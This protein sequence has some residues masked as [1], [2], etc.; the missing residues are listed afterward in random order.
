MEYT[1][2]LTFVLISAAQVATPGPSTLLLVN[3]ALSLGRWRA[4][5]AL[6]GDLLAIALLAWLSVVGIAALLVTHPAVFMTVRLMGAAYVVWLGWLYLRRPSPIQVGSTRSEPDG[7]RNGVKL[8]LYSFG[9]GISNPKAILF[10]AALFPQ[11]IPPGSGPSLLLVLVL[12]FVF[13]KLV[14]LGAYAFGARRIAR[15]LRKPE[16]ARR[17]RNLTGV[18]FIIFG[19]VMVWSAITT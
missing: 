12:T 17:G 9:V 16:H 4:I 3:N 1:A 11:F 5:S 8:W 15:L 7:K 2:Y 13:V 19:A 14:V 6:S 18:I 10:F